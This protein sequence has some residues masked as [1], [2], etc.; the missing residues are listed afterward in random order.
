MN[1]EL[2]A[3]T[4]QKALKTL[5]TILK[6]SKSARGSEPLDSS[7]KILACLLRG[8]LLNEVDEWAQ[9]TVA[10]ATYHQSYRSP[11]DKVTLSIQIAAR[12]KS[13]VQEPITSKKIEGL[14]QTTIF[15]E[16]TLDSC[17][18]T[19]IDNTIPKE[20]M[21]PRCFIQD[22]KREPLTASPARFLFTVLVEVSDAEAP[23][24][25]KALYNN[26]GPWQIGNVS[27]Q[28][29]LTA[30]ARNTVM[31]VPEMALALNRLAWQLDP[32]RLGEPE[33]EDILL[34][35]LL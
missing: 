12:D 8:K 34:N 33:I 19:A 26:R 31:L 21:P 15:P 14:V 35:C 7:L 23:S 16:V 10:L 2:Y 13:V 6:P 28:L 1:L 22:P 27:Y 29:S 11:G 20:R 4:K 30:A 24:L 32:L 5:E 9:G 25:Y 17:V 3:G 18:V